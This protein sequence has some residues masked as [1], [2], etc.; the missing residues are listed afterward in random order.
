[1]TGR[2]TL[3][4]VCLMLGSASGLGGCGYRAWYDGMQASEMQRQA[5]HPGEPRR[6]LPPMDFGTYT[7]ERDRLKSGGTP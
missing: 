3:L 7:A 5:R 6:T 2:R 4:A 1:M